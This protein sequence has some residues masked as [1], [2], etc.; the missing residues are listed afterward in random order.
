MYITLNG[1]LY[2]KSKIDIEGHRRSNESFVLLVA[3][4]HFIQFYR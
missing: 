1:K 3:K 4:T 2:A